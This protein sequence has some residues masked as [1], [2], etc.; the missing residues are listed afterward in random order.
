MLCFGSLKTSNNYDF[1]FSYSNNYNDSYT[2]FLSKPII[3]CIIVTRDSC[4]IASIAYLYILLGR[5]S[6]NL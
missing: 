2:K 1:S 4:W 5:V 3:T 6:C